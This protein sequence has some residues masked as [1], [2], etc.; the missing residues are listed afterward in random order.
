MRGPPL[1]WTKTTQKMEKIMA[2][3]TPQPVKLADYT[4]PA[5][6]VEQVE[7]TVKL[8]PDATHVLARLDLRPNPAAQRGPLVLNGEKMELVAV[9]LNGEPLAAS[10][11]VLSGEMLTLAAMPSEPCVLQIETLLNP[12]ANTELSGLYRSNGMYCT[13]CEAEGFRRITYFPDRPDVL[14][15]YRVR[16][17]GEKASNP[18]LLSNGNLVEAGELSGGWHYVVWEDPFPKPSYLFALVAGDLACETDHFSTMGGRKVELRIYTEHGKQDRCAWAMESLKR[19]MTWDEEAFGREYDLDIFMIVAVSDFNMGAMENKGLNIFNDKYILALPETAT[20][21]D[22]AQIEAIIAHEYFH[23]W[24]GNRITCRDWFQLCLKEGLTVFRDQEF[25]S[26]LRSRSV[27]RIQ[28]VRT[29]RMQQ[30]PEDGGPLSHPVRPSSYVEINNFYTATV[31]EKGAELVRM[32]KTLMGDQAFRAAMDLYFDRHDGQACT[33]EDFVACMTEASGRDFSPFFRWY[34]Q[35]GT[36]ELIAE[37][38]YDAAAG[39]FELTLTQHQTQRQGEAEKLPLHMPIALGLVGPN[40]AD[41]PLH[42]E[43]HGALSRSVIELKERTQR[44]RFTDIGAEP[45]LSLNRGFSAPVKVSM[46][47]KPADALFLM[48]HD[49]DSFNRWEAGQRLGRELIF[50]ALKGETSGLSSYAKALNETVMDATLEPA[51]R[52]LL[53]QLPSAADIAGEMGQNADPG[54]IHEAREKVRAGLGERMAAGLSQ[55]AEMTVADEYA[56]D[57]RQAGLRALRYA[58]LGLIS[59]A[60]PSRGAEMALAAFRSASN[61]TDEMGAMNVLALMDVPERRLALDEFHSRHRTDHLL[62][63]KWLALE[64]M[65]PFLSTVGAV[66][67]L[68]AHADFKLTT[69]NKV[70]SLIGT[71]AS[72]NPVAFNA[73]GGEGY[74]LVADVILRLD[75]MNPQ[76]AARLCGSFR[77]FRQLEPVRWAQAQAA[78]RQILAHPDLSRDTQEIAA[79]CLG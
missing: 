60:E 31:Y 46:A 37:S 19:S 72:L 4:P 53:L 33:M 3:D 11:Y 79:R 32:M 35:A 2:P 21:T 24:T 42:L 70:R 47:A 57:P 68:L 29:L 56:P 17:E 40:G 54:L 73:G 59:A 14:S 13:Q 18:V 30:F 44:F 69:P 78:L 12:A 52:A 16:M 10:A 45:V 15:R 75:A 8:H 71:F 64:A 77:S 65:G 27:K 74:R 51:F 22:F 25:S 48:R 6:L 34:T 63:D 38:R 41:L 28:D 55:L 67:K 43:G 5:W 58:A 9:T 36:P 50:A 76:V 61:M 49:S 1:E 66:E 62:I 20:D 23:N 39:V 7:L 26:D